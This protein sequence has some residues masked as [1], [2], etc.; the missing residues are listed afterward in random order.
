M[1]EILEILKGRVSAGLDVVVV[2]WVM[3]ER[4]VLPLKR[5]A[6]QLCDYIRAKDPTREAMEEIEDNVIVERKAGLVGTGV[7]VSTECIVIVFSVSHHPDLVS[8]PPYIFLLVHG[9][10]GDC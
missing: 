10:L 3:V 9:L 1:T 8:C 6:N 4:H 2:L 7:V 5:R